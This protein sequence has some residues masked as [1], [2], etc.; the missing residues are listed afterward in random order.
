MKK[1]VLKGIVIVAGIFLLAGCSKGS[2]PSEKAVKA[3]PS[4]QTVKKQAEDDANVLLD[5]L[6]QDKKSSQLENVTNQSSEGITSFLLTKLVEKQDQMFASNQNKDDY[7]LVIDGSNY[8]A[9]DIVKDY[10][11]A[12]LKQAQRLS[13]KV[14]NVTVNG[15]DAKVNVSYSP[16]ASLEEA[17]PIGTAR[18]KLF[19]G[20]DED[21]FIR[22]SQNKDI[23]TIKSLITL[24]LYGIYYGDLDY[25]AVK[26]K[27]P[28]DMSF[29]L[30]KKGTHFMANEDVIYQVVKDSR[31]KSYQDNTAK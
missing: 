25:D 21:T 6:Y 18:T 28:V 10:A 29:T 12:Y 8:Y 19:G 2:Q 26:V 30:T 5:F 13:F 27:N 3:E 31:I 16:I 1:T 15:D 14:K 4:A 7:Y 11:K 24:K 9:S 17:N 22:Q 20:I 23:K